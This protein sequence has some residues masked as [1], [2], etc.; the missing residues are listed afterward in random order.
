MKMMYL[1]VKNLNGVIDTNFVPLINA[2]GNAGKVINEGDK[3]GDLKDAF[4]MRVGEAGRGG[5]IIRHK[6][7]VEH[8][9]LPFE[10]HPSLEQPSNPNDAWV[11]TRDEYLSFGWD[12]IE[13]L[14]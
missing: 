11:S 9:I 1:V 10:N 2:R 8:W 6:N 3:W 14:I 7:S 5:L 4:Q 13:E 12:I